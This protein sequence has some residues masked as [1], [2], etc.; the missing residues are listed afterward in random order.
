MRKEYS[1]MTASRRAL[2]LLALAV[3]V[4]GLCIGGAAAATRGGAV[5]VSVVAS[6]LLNPRGM[7]F[8]FFGN[9]YVSEGGSGGPAQ[10][11]DPKLCDQVPGAGPYTGG[12]TSR[13]TRIDRFG[14][15]KTLVD[16]L[17]SSAT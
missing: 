3:C 8:D 5:D 16:H 11:F 4:A 2:G 12:F 15:Q 1:P 6:G 17:P 9:L 7:T 14:H 13:I 10:T